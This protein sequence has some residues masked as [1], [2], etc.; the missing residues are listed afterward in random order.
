MCVFIAH[1]YLLDISS[2]LFLS[3][4]LVKLKKSNTAWGAIGEERLAA[5][6]NNI[7]FHNIKLLSLFVHIIE[8]REPELRERVCFIIF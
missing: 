5:F 8:G 2:S 4:S 6:A 7:L 3:C 1:C